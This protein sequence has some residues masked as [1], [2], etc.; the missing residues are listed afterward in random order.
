MLKIVGALVGRKRLDEL[1]DE[2]Q[3][4]LHGACRARAQRRLQLRECHLDRIE[5]GRIGWQIPHLGADG[6]DCFV[7]ALDPVGAQVV[8]EHG[9]AIAQRRREYLLDVGEEAHRQFAR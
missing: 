4:R 7:H 8:H 9:I 1:S 5:V 3:E 6:L 2:P